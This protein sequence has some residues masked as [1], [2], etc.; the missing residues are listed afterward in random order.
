VAALIAAV[1]V[2]L[3]APEPMVPMSLFRE[4]TVVLAVLASLVVGVVMFGGTVFLGQYFQTARSFDPTEAGLLTL[5]LIAGLLVASTGSGQLISRYGRW[6]P[7]LVTGAVLITSGLGLLATIDHTTPILEICGFLVVLGLGVGMSMQNLVLAVQNT[8]E[9]RN[10]GAASSL[11]SFLRSLGGTIGVTVLGVVLSGRVAELLGGS[12][13]AAGLSDL[14]TL[15]PLQAEALRA[16]YGD[17]IGLVFGISAVA[18][19]ISLAAVLLIKEVPLRD[20]LDRQPTPATPR[21]ALA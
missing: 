9:L 16:A 18:S 10:M 8:V 15:S 20:T 13:A 2:E 4:R 19:L 14:E 7:F 1:V 21:A 12:A 5:P 17:G 11:V 3:R 6:K